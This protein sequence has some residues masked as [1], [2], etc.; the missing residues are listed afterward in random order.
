MLKV[1]IFVK[2]NKQELVM[3]KSRYC[4]QAEETIADLDA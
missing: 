3:S 4:R 2:N 1:M